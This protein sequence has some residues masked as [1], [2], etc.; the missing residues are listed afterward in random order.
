MIIWR[1]F[2]WAVPVI[3][4]VALVLTQIIVDSVYGRGFYGAN[5]W[6]KM[7]AIVAG[8]VLVAYL[9][10]VLNYRKRIVIVDEDTGKKRKS[11]SHSLFFIPVQFWAVIIP[12]LFLWVESYSAEQEALYASY[13]EAPEVDDKYLVDYSE[14]FEGLDSEFKY[15]VMKIKSIADDNIEFFLSELSYDGKS[16]PRVDVS[17]G[18]A[19]SKGY[20]IEDSMFFTLDELQ[21]L[22]QRDGIY[23]IVRN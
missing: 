14:V 6:T 13:L 10:Y 18:K 19:N 8:S 23:S 17:E 3:V 15:G 16:G 5:E 20:F 22:K 12:A 4:I 21:D 7:T 11:P 1:G 9:G 2:G